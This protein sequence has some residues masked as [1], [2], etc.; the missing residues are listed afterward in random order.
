MNFSLSILVEKQSFEL[1]GKKRNFVNNEATSRKLSG[2]KP[3]IF[4]RAY[5]H[6]KA[7]QSFASLAI[8]NGI[9]FIK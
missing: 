3:E 9:N 7:K 4:L 6:T 1:T 5:W 8:P 2:L